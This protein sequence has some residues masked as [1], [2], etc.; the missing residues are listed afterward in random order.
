ME[1]MD[2]YVRWGLKILILHKYQYGRLL[3]ERSC[4]I[5]SHM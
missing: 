2:V 4:V 5:F 1:N 3:L